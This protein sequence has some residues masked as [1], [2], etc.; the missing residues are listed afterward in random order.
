MTSFKP[1]NLERGEKT[2]FQ[3]QQ[4]FTD[5]FSQT[6][7]F[8]EDGTLLSINVLSPEDIA[9]YIVKHNYKIYKKFDDYHFNWG[10]YRIFEDTVTI[11]LQEKVHQ[12]GIIEICRWQGIISGNKLRIL[13]INKK[14]NGG[15]DFYTFSR[16]GIMLK[17][18]SNSIFENAIIDHKLSWVNK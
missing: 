4:V 12:W 17:A 6:V 9:E 10:I 18:V 2:S 14:S 1:F 3:E 15:L 13:P 5:S 11:E 7:V 8:F 16:N